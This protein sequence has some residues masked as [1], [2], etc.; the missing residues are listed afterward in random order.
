LDEWVLQNIES[1]E[2]GTLILNSICEM[3]NIPNSSRKAKTKLKKQL[4]NFIK[5][6]FPNRTNECKILTGSK[7]GWVG[8]RIKIEE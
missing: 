1:Y 8:I 7:Y 5:D 4:E 2:G 3:R 6:H